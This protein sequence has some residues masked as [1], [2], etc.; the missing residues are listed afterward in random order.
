M[1]FDNFTIKAQEAVNQAVKI[2]EGNNQQA[3]DTGHLL[4]GLMVNAES[5]IGF[6]LKKLGV[7]VVIFNAALDKI[8][9]SYPK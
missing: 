2:A 8:I 9:V 3:I 1:N 5:V 6:L 7:N 4:K